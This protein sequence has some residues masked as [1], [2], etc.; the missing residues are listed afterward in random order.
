MIKSNYI[1]IITFILGFAIFSLLA[2]FT[3]SFFWSSKYSYPVMKM[4]SIFLGDALLLPII[5]QL[6]F[7]LFKKMGYKLSTNLKL[8]IIIFIISFFLNYITHFKVWIS[9]EYLGFMDLE[10]N[11]LSLAGYW[12]FLFSVFE[13]FIIG[14][15]IVE[16]FKIM[17]FHPKLRQDYLRILLLIIVFTSIGLLDSIFKV[18]FVNDS[19]ENFKMN[20]KLIFSN[21]ENYIFLIITSSI[22]LYYKYILI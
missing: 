7:N 16:G 2:I 5:N 10:Y 12:H 21:F 17:K 4:P 22:Y 13:M 3:E 1:F 18:Y 14:V 9:D 15:V 6:A 8:I 11:R 20:L 19:N